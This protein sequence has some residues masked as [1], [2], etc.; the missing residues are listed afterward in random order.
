MIKEVAKLS[1]I[2]FGSKT[3]RQLTFEVKK[4]DLQLVQRKMFWHKP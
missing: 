4:S 2:C 3:I 1:K